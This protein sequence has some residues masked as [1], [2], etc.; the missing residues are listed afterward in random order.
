MADQVLNRLQQY[1]EFSAETILT[2]G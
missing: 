1:K 2:G